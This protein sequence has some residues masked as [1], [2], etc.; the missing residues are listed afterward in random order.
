MAGGII[1]G[2][3]AGSTPGGAVEVD[4][5]RDIG[6]KLPVNFF[7]EASGISKEGRENLV[8][9][10]DH[11]FN[12]L[13]P[14]N[15]LVEQ[16]RCKAA[17]YTEWATAKCQRD[18]L[19]SSDVTIGG[20]TIPEASRVMLCFAAANRD[21]RR[22]ETPTSSTSPATRPDTCPSA[23]ASTGAWASTQ[24]ASRRRHCWNNWCPGSRASNWPRRSNATTTT[25]YVAGT[26]C[27][28]G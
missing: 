14:D 24:P 5:H 1:D 27:P 25:P 6:S 12:A 15:E 16:G 23:W 10:A 11:T 4:G 7:P 20:S 21:P 8:P 3:L 18:A 19:K 13:G 26:L 9:Y 2:L 22:W 17:E 28:C